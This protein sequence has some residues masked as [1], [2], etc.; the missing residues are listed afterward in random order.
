MS[1][2]IISIGMSFH[3]FYTFDSYLYIGMP[4]FCHINLS[5]IQYKQLSVI[6]R[7]LMMP[8]ICLET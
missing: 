7:G 2:F 1:L 6:N 5:F 3:N 4:L 8:L